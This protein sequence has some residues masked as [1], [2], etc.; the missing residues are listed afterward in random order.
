VETD[1]CQNALF[2]NPGF[3]GHWVTLRI[4]G[5][6]SNRDGI[7]TRIAL[8]VMDSSGAARTIYRTVSA[9]G[10]FGGGSLQEEIGLG[11]ADSIVR[12]TL[13]WP[14][15][16]GEQVVTGLQPGRTWRLIQGQATAVD[17]TLPP[18][19]FRTKQME[20]VHHEGMQHDMP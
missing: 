19:P 6:T 8:D 3:G 13:T 7:G 17:E 16:A 5:N 15:K 2:E 20:H 18:L 9:G 14:G 11:S 10:S 1:F 4:Q 12:C